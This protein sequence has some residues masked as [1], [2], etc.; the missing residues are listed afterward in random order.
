[1]IDE[2]YD[3]MSVMHYSADT[4]ENDP[5]RHESKFSFIYKTKTFPF[6]IKNDQFYIQ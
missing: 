6:Y 4:D 1:M 3:F 5:T 2:P